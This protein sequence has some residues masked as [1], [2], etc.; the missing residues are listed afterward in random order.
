MRISSSR[1]FP[2]RTTPYIRSHMVMIARDDRVVVNTDQFVALVNIIGLKARWT[3]I[4]KNGEGTEMVTWAELTDSQRL[5]ARMAA[6]RYPGSGPGGY[7]DERYY[8]LEAL[9]ED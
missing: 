9:I 3:F 7:Q 5:S 1:L 4:T 2:P 8:A 6:K